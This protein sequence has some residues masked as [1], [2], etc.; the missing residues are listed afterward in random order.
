MKGV[1]SAIHLSENALNTYSAPP[2]LGQHTHEVLT[3]LLGYTSDEVRLLAC[4]G[5]V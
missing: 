5:V 1:K 3:A 2:T 4:E